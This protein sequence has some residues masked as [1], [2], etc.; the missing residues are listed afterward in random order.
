PST[1]SLFQTPNLRFNV[2]TRRLSK[3]SWMTLNASSSGQTAS[4]LGS[5]ISGG[6]SIQT[7]DLLRAFRRA[8]QASKQHS[9]LPAAYQTLTSRNSDLQWGVL[10]TRSSFVGSGQ[11][12]NNSFK[13]RPLRGL[14]RA[15]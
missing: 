7:R 1:Q 6:S 5:Q 3:L 2:R 12:P 11:R 13:P 14:G 9:I 8:P 15:S 4:D 10:R